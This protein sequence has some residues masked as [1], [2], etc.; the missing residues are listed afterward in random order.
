MGINTK[1]CSDDN[2]TQEFKCQCKNG[3]GGERCELDLCPTC[4][5]NGFCPGENLSDTSVQKP[6]HCECSFPYEGL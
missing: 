3:F 1:S 5:N 2:G 4:E 6:L